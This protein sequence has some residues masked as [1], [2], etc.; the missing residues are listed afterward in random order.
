MATIREMV[1]ALDTFIE[2]GDGLGVVCIKGFPDFRQLNLQPPLA[3]LFYAGSRE[4]Q[5]SDVR[6][7]IGVSASTV[8]LTLGVYASNEA[9]LFELMMALQQVRKNKPVLSAGVTNQKVRIYVGD[10]ERIEPDE[11]SPKEERH[12]VRAA[13]VLAYE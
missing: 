9:E 11:E 10:D 7:R 12:W 1:D 6:R 2:S 8:V 4:G 13:V 5:A 3:A